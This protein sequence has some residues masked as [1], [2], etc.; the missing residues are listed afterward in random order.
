[1]GITNLRGPAKWTYYYLNVMLDNHSRCAVVW[2]LATRECAALAQKPITDTAPPSIIW[3]GAP[4]RPSTLH[5]WAHK[6]P[7][8]ADRFRFLMATLRRCVHS[9]GQ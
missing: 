4:E 9:L 5:G 3:V 6:R 7:V 8:L 1:M 2:M